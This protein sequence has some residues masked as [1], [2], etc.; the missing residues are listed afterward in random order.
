MTD[1]MHL[2]ENGWMSLATYCS[3]TQQ[4]LV[5]CSQ[6]Q[7]VRAALGQSGSTAGWESTDTA[8]CQVALLEKSGSNIVSFQKDLQNIPRF[9]GKGPA[10]VA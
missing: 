2:K 7:L 6:N 5:E 9:A 10:Q 3:C 8:E 1:G 4:Q